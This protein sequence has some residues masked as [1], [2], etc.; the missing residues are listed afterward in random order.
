MSD[1]QNEHDEQN[2][3]RAR[4]KEAAEAARVAA[5]QAARAFHEAIAR[6][7]NVPPEQPRLRSAI[8]AALGIPLVRYGQAISGQRGSLPTV[9]SWVA[10][11]NE[12][13][14]FDT[15]DGAA[16]RLTLS[17]DGG[18]WTCTAEGGEIR[19]FLLQSL[20]TATAPDAA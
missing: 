14:A 8:C 15:G 20:L 17:S 11:W 7:L 9:Q 12:A 2:E 5:H 13:A 1:E 16:P 4:A 3:T 19:S 10:K 6:M 18:Q